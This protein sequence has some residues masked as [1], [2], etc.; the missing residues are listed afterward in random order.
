[1]NKAVLHGFAILFLSSLLWVGCSEPPVPRPRG[2]FRIELPEKDYRVF[3]SIYPFTFEFPAW[4][5]ISPNLRDSINEPWWI[6]IEY[7]AFKGTIYISYKEIN[8]NLNAYVSD[9]WEFVNKH[10][11][12]ADA[13]IQTDIQQAEHRVYGVHFSIEG[14]AAASPIQFYLTDST[15]HFLR[16]ALY[17]DLPPNNDSLQPII[18]FINQ[19]VMH[20]INT[21]KW[22]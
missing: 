9:S 1:M 7:A 12:K 14:A 13:I 21:L 8:N 10:I 5:R 15:K 6:N 16:A 2:Y 17:F 22:K 3:D 4:C 18:E 19:D 11:P 20:L